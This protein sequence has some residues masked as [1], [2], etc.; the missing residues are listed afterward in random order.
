[1]K[2]PP[3]TSDMFGGQKPLL[4]HETVV[5]EVARMLDMAPEALRE[6]IEQLPR[7]EIA[8]LVVPFAE[9]MGVAPEE[10]AEILQMTVVLPTLAPPLEDDIN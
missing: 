7:A 8:K 1:M 5:G 4:E 6:R 3:N 9:V 10:V 2:R